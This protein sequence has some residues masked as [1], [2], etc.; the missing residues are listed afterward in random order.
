MIFVN[1]SFDST[2]RGSLWTD[3][4]LTSNETIPGFTGMTVHNYP[5]LGSIQADI[6]ALNMPLQSIVPDDP[7][8]PENTSV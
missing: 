4:S 7:T 3:I 5:N 6:R 2:Q 1:R 8:I